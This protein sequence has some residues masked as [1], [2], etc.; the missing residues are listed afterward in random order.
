MKNRRH[1]PS[2][3]VTDIAFLLLLFFL[4]LAIST[5]QTPV[6]IE[7]A[8]TNAELLEDTEVPTLLV[9]SDGQLFLD[10]TPLLLGEIPNQETYALLADKH[11]S[12]ET[13][14][15]ILEQLKLIGVE[16]VYCLVEDEQ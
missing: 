15:A 4:I 1:T 6:P 16:T 5:H 11:T 14:H 13:M 10:G 2:S 12:Y 9:S 7:A 3:T 8:A